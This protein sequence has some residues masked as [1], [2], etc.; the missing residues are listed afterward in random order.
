MPPTPTPMCSRVIKSKSQRGAEKGKQIVFVQ[1]VDGGRF[2]L[3][4][5]FI[6]HWL[7]AVW[8]CCVLL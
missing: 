5:V 3:L 2:V 4:E 7:L 6:V 1:V 8:G